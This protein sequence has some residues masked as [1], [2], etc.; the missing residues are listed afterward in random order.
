MLDKKLTV[1]PRIIV[2]NTL[3]VHWIGRYFPTIFRLTF[4]GLQARFGDEI[5]RNLSTIALFPKRDYCP[6]QVKLIGPINQKYLQC[7]AKS[8]VPLLPVRTA[9]H[10]W[11]QTTHNLSIT[12][13][14]S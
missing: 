13:D 7:E 8:G 9:V 10:C 4:F 1:A 5:T 6:K 3:P 11:G 14:H 2:Q 12:G